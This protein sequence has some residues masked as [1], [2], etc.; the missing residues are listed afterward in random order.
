[1]NARNALALLLAAPLF[2]LPMMAGC[3][4]D[5]AVGDDD[6]AVDSV[7]TSVSEE[8]LSTAA[9][10]F[11]GTFDAKEDA[12]ALGFLNLSLK[13]SGAFEATLVQV[14]PPGRV[15][16]QFVPVDTGTWSVT[17]KNGAYTLSLKTTSTAPA[18][19]KQYAIRKLGTG[20]DE[21]RLARGSAVQ[22]MRK[23][24]QATCASTTCAPNNICVDTPDG[25]E[26]RGRVTC[27]NVR[28]GFGTRCVDAAAGPACVPAVVQPGLWGGEQI[29]VD[30]QQDG[31]GNVT[32]SCGGAQINPIKLAA[33]GSG[34]FSVGG[35]FTQGSGIQRIDPDT[36]LPVRP[37]PQAA[38]FSGKVLSGGQRMNLRMVVAGGAPQDYVLNFNDN[39]RLFFCL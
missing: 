8:E 10:R 7:D 37:V 39:T 17:K 16:A 19:T 38:T 29:H 6:T 25:A 34:T 23:R 12:R 32:F 33:D 3:A 1:M 13:K 21:I 9:A 4:V 14:C 20:G 11:A 30:F 31:S 5:T 15:C 28:C 26:C 36:G 35:T 2:A 22:V 18:V 24:F 27:A